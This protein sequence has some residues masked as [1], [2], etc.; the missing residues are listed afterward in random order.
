M[1]TSSNRS[2]RPTSDTIT[3]FATGDKIDLSGI[4]AV[5]GGANDLF[6]YIGGSAFSHHAGELQVVNTGFNNWTVAAVVMVTAM[7]ISSSR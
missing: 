3:D 2:R 4:D 7:P 6:T 1:T 5:A